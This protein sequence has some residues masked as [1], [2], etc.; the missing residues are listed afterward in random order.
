VTALAAR[1]LR[2]VRA[3]GLIGPGD[4]VVAA[5]SGGPDSVAL[6]HLLREI[7]PSLGAEVAA[8]AHLH[9]GLRGEAADAD[10]R[11]CREVA[12]R[13]GVPFVVE[14]ADVGRLARDARWSIE[15]AGHVARARFY[16]RAMEET[17]AT[18]VATGHTRDDQAETVLLRLLRGA[19]TRGLGGIHPRRGRV[20]RP[21][22]GVTRA[23]I[24]RYL[25]AHGLVGR[26]DPTNRDV[27]IAR[28]RVRHELL[29]LVERRFSPRVGAALA[30]TA[31]LARDDEACLATLAREATWQLVRETPDGVVI[32]RGG[33][34]ALALALGRRVVRE[35]LGRVAGRAAGAAQVV[36]ALGL[37]LRGRPG[38]TLDA[39][40][41]RLRLSS[42]A[43]ELTAR[44][45]AVSPAAA[46]ASHSGPGAAERLPVPGTLR[47]APSGRVVSADLLGPD[48]VQSVVGVHG[49]ASD[50]A[51]VDAARVGPAVFVRSR[52][53]GDWLRPA[54]L[55]G[56]KKLQDL[57][58]D[59]KVPR[60]ER[61]LVPIV[62]DAHGRVVWVA[63]HSVSEEFG[64][65]PATTGVLLLRVRP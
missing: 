18:L 36:Q 2:A 19:G 20:V 54:G 16:G 62:V 46:G 64:V 32:A 24:A 35:A 59:R 15:H 43:V 7:L 52:R 23:E 34:R 55:G 45:A 44:A 61:D 48:D 1:V 12:P 51:A 42:E 14:H 3:A 40:G 10:E 58:V 37:A 25:A 41:V 28:N 50:V 60:A 9:H 65:T 31:E 57:F 39:R 27:T 22:L 21:L 5:L 13:L 49:A 33:L 6:L 17:G 26:D 29:P 30:R 47:H 63:G 53:P 11:F 8:I 4:R 56:R 38:A